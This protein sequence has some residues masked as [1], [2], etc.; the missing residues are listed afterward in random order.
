MQSSRDSK[1]SRDPE[2]RCQNECACQ[3]P[4]ITQRVEVVFDFDAV[5]LLQY[6]STQ[7]VTFAEMNVSN[8]SIYRSLSDTVAKVEVIWFDTLASDQSLPSLNV[9]HT[10]FK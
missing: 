7:R 8:F 4:G 2:S 6:P 3:N 9:L 10:N 5:V 1:D